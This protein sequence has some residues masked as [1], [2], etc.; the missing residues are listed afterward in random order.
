MA[1][2]LTFE[3]LLGHGILQ[4]RGREHYQVDYDLCNEYRK[5]FKELQDKL[6]DWVKQWRRQERVEDELNHFYLEDNLLDELAEKLIKHAEI[7][8]LVTSP[9]VERC[10][11]SNS[12]ISAK[13]KGIRVTLVT[14]SPQYDKYNQQKREKYH[15]KLREKSV[16]VTYDNSVHAK[17][18]VIDRA[19]AIVSSMNF[20]ASSS[21]GAS[22]EAGLVTIE[23]NVVQSIYSSIINKLLP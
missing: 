9:F 2:N 10:H 6:V 17:L 19:V 13:S 7:D 16:L 15:L 20:L 3:E 1:F 14:H 11:L 12:L 4:K 5:F 18:I 23:Q 21:G 22:Y 8:V